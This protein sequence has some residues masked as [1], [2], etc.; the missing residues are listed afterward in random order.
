MT[1]K[2]KQYDVCIV[3]AGPAGMT[4]GIYASRYGLKTL[5]I[6]KE[7]GGKGNHPGK[8]ENYPGFVGT[9]LELM[10]KMLSQVKH[11][12]V[13]VLNQEVLSIKKSKE[14]FEITTESE[15]ITS[16]AIIIASGT[17]KKK[18]GVK[19][20]LELIGKGVSYCAT[21][22]AFFFKKKDVAVIGGGEAAAKTALFLSSLA[23][24]V[25][26]IYRGDKLKCSDKEKCEL[27]KNV[28]IIYNSQVREIR[29]KE[30][31]ESILLENREIKVSGVFIEIG[32]VPVIQLIEQLGVQGDE[33]YISVDS[34]M[35]T[36]IP[37]IFS[38]GD[39]TNTKLK[40]VV[41]ACSQGA[42]AAK[43][44]YDYLRS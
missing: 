7:L 24:K 38:A 2:I 3:G 44:A 6:G 35:R 16:K 10:E 12:Q 11:F 8:I 17:E 20:E 1:A 26:L 4:A 14:G 21:C 37:G 36:N 40:Q 25:Y 41:V 29:G 9:G 5:I 33:N 27:E 32:S 34:S 28:E 13:P 42:I 31:V 43:S 22:D 30:Q 15:V 39:I 19:G 18:L 23:K